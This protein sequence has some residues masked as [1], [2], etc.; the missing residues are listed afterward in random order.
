MFVDVNL[1]N[2]QER[3]TVM[4]GDTAESL[5]QEFGDK[6]D[7]DENMRVKLRTLL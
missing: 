4:E 3:I 6:H 2:V 5:T 1:G 7:L